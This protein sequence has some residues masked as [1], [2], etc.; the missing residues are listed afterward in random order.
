MHSKPMHL[1]KLSYN[2]YTWMILGHSWGHFPY[3]SPPFWGDLGGLVTVICPDVCSISTDARH[4]GG[5]E[6]FRQPKSK[7]SSGLCTH[8]KSMGRT[9]YSPT[10]MVDLYIF[11]VYRYKNIP[12]PWIHNGIWNSE[13]ITWTLTHMT[14]PLYAT[15]KER[16]AG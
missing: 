1:G 13:T 14:I 4:W 7:E 12:V 11:H 8:D 5:H 2:S 10:W 9:V 16:N 6:F 3:F 15:L